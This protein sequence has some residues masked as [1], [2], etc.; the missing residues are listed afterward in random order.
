MKTT[1]ILPALVAFLFSGAASAAV[2]NW[3]GALAGTNEVPPNASAFKGNAVCTY[4]DVTKALACTIT[5]NVT[6]PTMGHIH[7][8]AKTVNGGVVYTFPTL[9]SPIAANTTLNGGQENALKASGLY[10]NIHTAANPTGEIRAQLEPITLDAG[11]DGSTE[12]GPTLPDASSS[13][14]SSSS[15]GGSSSSSSSSSSSGA[16]GTSTSSGNSDSGGCNVA[17]SESSPWGL[18]GIAVGVALVLGATRKRRA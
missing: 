6:T 18:A 8:G 15:S 3:G 10:V 7:M 11:T 13:S 5:H 12:A 17:S 1:A 9:V 14:S 16:S 2:T 4:D